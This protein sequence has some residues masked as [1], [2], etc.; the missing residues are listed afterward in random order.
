M[1]NSSSV[2]V[3]APIPNATLDQILALLAQLETLL[4]PY[5][6]SLTDD[7]RRKL[8]KMGAES[9]SFVQNGQ[10]AIDYS[11]D[12]MPRD[13]DPVEFRNAF[14]L[15]QQLEPLAARL[16]SMARG[17][18]DGEMVYGS[19]AYTEALEIYAQVG[20]AS[21]KDSAFL[22]FYNNMKQRFDKLRGKR[23]APPSP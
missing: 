11:I 2:P 9:V 6:R 16:L 22:V 7:E 12:F 17:V 13:F 21:K 4:A 10:N 14:A 8:A 18:E 19:L 15:S 3:P 5:L 20:V 23:P 1:Q